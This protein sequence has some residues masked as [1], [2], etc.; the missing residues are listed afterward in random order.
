MAKTGRMRRTLTIKRETLTE[1]ERGDLAAVVAAS[2]SCPIRELRDR[3]TKLTEA[4]AA[5]PETDVITLCH[6]P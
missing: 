3:I 2:V 4:I 5:P 1:L 6:C